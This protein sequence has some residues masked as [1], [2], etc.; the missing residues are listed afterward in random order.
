M[1][2]QTSRFTPIFVAL[3]VV[4]GILLGSFLANHLGGK[5]VNIINSSSSKISDMLHL[6]DDYY[7]DS[8]DIENLTERALPSI[9]R[10]LD[11][12]SKYISAADVE[13]SMQD[14]NGSFSGIGVRFSIFNDTV[15]VVKVVPGGPSEK[16]GLKAG[17]RI[18][19]VNDKPYIGKDVVTNDSTM[20][21]LKGPKGT[22]VKLTI[23]RRGQ[24]A[25][26]TTIVRDDVPLSSVDA[27]YMLDKSAAYL[28]I[29]TFGS[30]T[31]DEFMHAME[32]LETKGMKSLVIDLRGNLGGYMETAVSIANEFLENN[33]LI[34][35]TQGRKSPREERRSNGNGRYQ[36]MPI[37]LLV[38]ETSASASEIMAGAFQDNDRAIIVGRRTFGKGLV[39]V[40]IEFSDGSM[41]R[42]TKA[43]YYTPSGRCLQ[44][45]YSPGD[46]E[47]YDSDLLQRA[48]SGEYFSE[49]SIKHSEEKYKTSIG[50]TVYGGGGIIPDIFIPK[51]TIGAT[52]YLKDVVL[53]GLTNKYSFFFVDSNREKLNKLKTEADL[54]NYLNSV[55]LVELFAQYAEKNGVSR[56]NDQIN[57]SSKLIKDY[58]LTSILLDQFDTQGA[59]QYINRTDE[60]VLKALELIKA[61]KTYPKLE[62]PTTSK[63]ATAKA[64]VKVL[65]AP[66]PFMSLPQTIALHFVG[67]A[68][69]RWN[70][71]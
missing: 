19:A 10:E 33:Q 44:K 6:I 67:T 12:H 9:L 29:T 71:G 52:D 2:K 56:N 68:H 41:L 63:K 46:E 69:R 50:R 45:P 43:R 35:Y 13:A 31:Y 49:D 24:K 42:L 11:P 37:V 66:F 20:K 57:K 32:Q 25:F 60:Y 40:P 4:F 39:Q 70:N 38:D 30:T 55:N 47:E 15:C 51:D 3:G 17:D 21:L 53:K 59:V 58:L 22:S 36:K 14:L 28:R 5:R 64:F 34:V 23:Q 7:V 65:N 54:E 18:V 16:I 48:I 1:A 8:I 26:Q 61:N 62:T 27:A